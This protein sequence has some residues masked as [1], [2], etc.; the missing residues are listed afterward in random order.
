MKNVQN[1]Y[2]RYDHEFT[3]ILAI[4]I[5]ILRLVINKIKNK[6]SAIYDVN[7]FRAYTVH[8][9]SNIMNEF[10]DLIK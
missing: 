5:H 8:S 2:V 9:R 6:N 1:I 4:Y 3:Y 7:F 10:N